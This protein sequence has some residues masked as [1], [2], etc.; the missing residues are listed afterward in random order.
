[1]KG[2]GSR[3][4]PPA[5]FRSVTP[6]A[7]AKTRFVIVD[8]VGVTEHDFVDP[9]LN[10]I[11]GVTLKKLLDKAATLSL[12]EDETATLASRL[13]KLQLELTPA[14]RVELDDVAGGPV[15]E[16]IRGLVDAVDPD[17]QAIVIGGATDAAVAVQD[18]LDAAIKP[19]AA[20]P[21]L[22]GRILELRATHDRGTAVERRLRQGIR[23]GP[24]LHPARFDPGHR[25]RHPPHHRRHGRRPGLRHRRI[26]TGGP[27]PRLGRCRIDDADPAGQAA[28]RLRPRLR[29]GRRHRSAGRDEPAA[30]RHGHR[31]RRLADRGPRF[32]DRRPWRA[33]V[34]GAV[35]P[36]VRPQVV[37][38]HDRRG[39]P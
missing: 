1:M 31:E 39:R 4:I 17:V 37:A 10:R 23:C 24:V 26:F 29:A 8:A 2:R 13:A 32:T 30:A 36:A 11:K 12:T 20:N 16:V 9:P 7:D 6:D 33:L 35:E 5:D 27:R 14:E 15:R 25:R 21:E 19:I 38:H 18:L 34:G 22:S 3:T 28:R